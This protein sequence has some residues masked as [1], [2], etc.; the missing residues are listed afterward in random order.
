[1]TIEEIAREI[2]EQTWANAYEN[3]PALA[4][5]FAA[6][7]SAAIQAE[8]EACAKIAEDEGGYEENTGSAPSDFGNEGR[9]RASRDIAAAI[10][11]RT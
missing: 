4:R 1:M 5:R 6:A 7:L 8:R 3:R 2:A 11:S 9:N 10:R